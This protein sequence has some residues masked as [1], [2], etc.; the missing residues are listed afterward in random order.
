MPQ[1]IRVND[2]IAKTVNCDGERLNRFFKK[3]SSFY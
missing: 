1:E 2:I 3:Q